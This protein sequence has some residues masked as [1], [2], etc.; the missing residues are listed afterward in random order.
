MNATVALI[1]IA[2]W[3]ALL[4]WGVHMVQSGIQRAFGPNLRRA[5]GMALGNRIKA[6]LAGLG[7]TA[8]LQSSTATALMATSFTAGG[9]IEMVP[10]LAVV[11]GANVGTTLIVQL[12]SFDVSEA[13]P[14]LVLV[15]LVMF[16]RG[17]L[18][19]T[20]DLGR[21][22]IGVG[23]MLLALRE[24][25]VVVAPYENAPAVRLLFDAVS[26]EPL[27]AIL[28][29]AALTWAA[30]SSVAI[31]LL[32]MSLVA[33]GVV[34]LHAGLALVLGANLGT[35]I[36]PLLESPGGDPA[37]R[38]LPLGNFLNRSVC[39][40]VALLFFDAVEPLLSRLEPDPGRAVADFHTAFNLLSA[41]VFLPLLG[42]WSNLLCRILRS[43]IKPLDPCR[44]V[45]L[46]EM[47]RETPPIALASAAREA[48]RM[49][50]ILGAMLE[51]AREAIVRGDRR[52]I[53]ETKRLDD[54]LD[55]LN[56]AITSYLTR[57]DPDELDL[58][59]NR[60]LSAILGFTTNLEHAGDVVE[61]NLMALA[62]KRLKRGPA[63]PV[64][65]IVEIRSMLERLE[66]NLRTAAAVFMTEDVRAARRLAEEKEFFRDLASH[67]AEAHFVRV[68]NGGPE[69]METGAMHLDVIR[70]LRRING[71]LVNAAYPILE[72]RGELLPSRLRQ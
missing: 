45:Y 26:A 43:R 27:I 42:P 2:G 50:D 69:S 67:A 14:F 64:E 53:G 62:G 4:L 7:V 28:F 72:E 6:F 29:A 10:A 36:N 11:L 60:R 56:A 9:L 70:E 54:V 35:A 16:R 17:N 51:G 12:L 1:D 63:L 33:Q 39:C 32:V 8:I 31:V 66:T 3:V 41:A 55:R 21:V 25:L 37:A 18:T 34:P 38:R 5:L 20:R 59:D 46:D 71:H 49:A 13:A 65:A 47:A 61:K 15:G 40:A 44:P 48:L 19:R 58:G 24:L 22:A 30:H 52:Q 57:L 68:R 23:L